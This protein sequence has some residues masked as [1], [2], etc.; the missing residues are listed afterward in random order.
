MEKFLFGVATSATQIEGAYNQDGKGLSIWDE[1]SAKGLIENNVT[2]FRACD[3][4]NRMEEDLK[5]L[6]ELP[7]KVKNIILF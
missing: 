5:N 2:C 4:Y 7:A 1:Y 3:S 6:E